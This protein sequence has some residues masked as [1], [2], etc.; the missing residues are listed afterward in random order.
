[1]AN[2]ERLFETTDNTTNYLSAPQYFATRGY[3]TGVIQADIGSGDQV[4]LQGRV[5]DSM[6]WLDILDIH[7]NPTI[8]EVV[9]APQMRVSVTNNSGDPL[10]VMITE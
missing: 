4:I 5:S 10:V 3:R 1:M 2:A 6:N 8:T 7:T 9:L